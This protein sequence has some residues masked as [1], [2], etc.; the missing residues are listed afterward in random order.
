MDG[1]AIDHEVH[2]LPGS[3][4][5]SNRHGIKPGALGA[6]SD[7]SDGAGPCFMHGTVSE[8]LGWRHTPSIDFH[9][10][11]CVLKC[12]CETSSFHLPATIT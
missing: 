2:N 1:C 11:F 5:R 8:A 3:A 6:G 9:P 12:G 7:E 4:R 10:L